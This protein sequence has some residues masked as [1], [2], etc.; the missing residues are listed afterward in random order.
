MQIAALSDYI[1]VCRK[2]QLCASVFVLSSLWMLKALTLT[3]FCFHPQIVL[4]S[5][6]AKFIGLW[7]KKNN[8]AVEK[9][10]LILF[11]RT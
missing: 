2:T 1:G 7:L 4:R 11:V 5:S 3:F 6:P 8:P 9:V 10:E